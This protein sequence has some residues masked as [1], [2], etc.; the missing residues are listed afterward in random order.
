M[1]ERA[2]L[3]LVAVLAAAAGLALGFYAGVRSGALLGS[4]AGG[5]TQAMVLTADLTDLRRGRIEVALS[6]M[7][8]RLDEAILTHAQFQ[9]AAAFRWV[10]YPLLNERRV[11]TYE[12]YMRKVAQYRKAYPRDAPARTV[13]ADDDVG[14]EVRQILR[15]YEK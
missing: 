3:T 9:D 2:R 5:A 7:E 15:K 14:Q 6:A 4:L 13:A 11:R 12:G 1:T 10:L 8:S